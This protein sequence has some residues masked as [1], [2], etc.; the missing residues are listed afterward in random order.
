MDNKTSIA[1][2]AL[3]VS[4][5]SLFIAG[6]AFRS[7]EKAR[8]H[9][10]LVNV[11]FQYGSVEM[12]QA[13]KTLWKFYE[14]HKE[15]LGE[16]Y[17]TI[18]RTDESEIE[19]LDPKQRLERERTTLHHQRRL[20]ENFY[21]LL[22]GFH[23]LKVIPKKTLYTYW[24]KDNLRIIP[25]IIIPIEKAMSKELGTDPEHIIFERMQKLYDD[26]PDDKVYWI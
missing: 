19:K 3:I 16:V 5:L 1:M 4:A 9:Q 25:D 13:I 8:M 2:I 18:L 23:K 21:S 22:A 15:N 20:V 12:L 26:C 6:K 10:V 14:K 17:I 7:A 11:M 24:N